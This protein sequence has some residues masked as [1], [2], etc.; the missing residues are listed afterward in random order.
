M[1]QIAAMTHKAPR[2]FPLLVIVLVLFLLPQTVTAANFSRL[3]VVEFSAARL[4]SIQAKPIAAIRMVA[5]DGASFAAIPFQLDRKN[6]QGK[7]LFAGDKGFE[8][9]T[10]APTDEFCL[11][12]DDLGVKAPDDRLAEI[13]GAI[14]LKVQKNGKTGFA[15]LGLLPVELSEKDYV[16]FEPSF[17]GVVTPYYTLAG[18]PEN[19]SFYSRLVLGGVDHIDRVKLRAVATLLFGQIQVERTENDIR[20]RAESIVDGPVRVI[21]RIHYS[22]RI[23]GN[24]HSPT[25]DRVTKNY[26][27]VNHLPN[28]LNIP[29]NPDLIFT[30]LQSLA[31][32][33]FDPGIAGATIHCSTCQEGFL[34]SGKMDP[35][36]FE[37]TGLG[38]RTFSVCSKYGT[39]MM[40]VRPSAEAEKL[41]IGTNGFF[42]DDQGRPDPPED[43]PGCFGMFGYRLTD[44]HK[45]KK[46]KYLFNVALL[47]PDQCPQKANLEI[48]AQEYL[49]PY[50]T[51]FRKLP[52]AVR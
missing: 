43:V 5:F 45:V 21:Y 20:G 30:D 25:I 24:I 47:F 38:S 16:R 50:T 18:H 3:F 17:S 41:P 52:D 1:L 49:G 34:I 4:P 15:Y 37:D 14:E 28:E 33:D 27:A 19:P 46:G 29:F 13:P 7:Y 40:A 26:K 42:L 36:E 9:K 10:L 35:F 2:P 32:F 44:L 31:A 12:G 6:K 51:T 39:F 8:R 11:Q 48:L 22:V 23:L